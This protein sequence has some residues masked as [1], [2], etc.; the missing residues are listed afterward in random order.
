MTNDI[1]PYEIHELPP[2]FLRM[3]LDFY[4]QDLN[5]WYDRY[6][7]IQMHVRNGSSYWTAVDV[8]ACRHYMHRDIAKVREYRAAL[9]RAT[10]EQVTE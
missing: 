9:A 1:R 7:Q 5:E 3:Q 4:V 2:I 8:E 6:R 10:G